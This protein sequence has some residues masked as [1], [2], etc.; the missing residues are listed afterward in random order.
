ME[1]R[2]EIL[3]DTQVHIN[4]ENGVVLQTGED[5]KTFIDEMFG[6]GS[7]DNY[8]K[9]NDPRNQPDYYLVRAEAGKKFV[10]DVTFMLL[11]NLKTGA[12]T[13]EQTMA[14]EETLEKVI[15]KLND[16][17][18]VTAKYKLT[19]VKDN[20]SDT[21]YTLVMTGIDNLISIHYA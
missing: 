13:L 12:A 7:Y 17:N 11:T 2:F 14:I 10:N 9:L 3:G 1:T 15:N 5:A 19:L 20:V 6:E 8:F 16:G 18:F 21:L 4:T